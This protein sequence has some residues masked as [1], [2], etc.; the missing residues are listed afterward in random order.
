MTLRELTEKCWYL[1]ELV[2]TENLGANLTN[3]C[4]WCLEITT[5]MDISLGTTAVEN[6]GDREIISFGTFDNYLVVEV[7]KQ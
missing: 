3:P 4:D 1:T 2:V 5:P 7:A 6:L